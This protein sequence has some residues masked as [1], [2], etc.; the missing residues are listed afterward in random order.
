[1][2]LWLVWLA[3]QMELEAQTE[4]LV[5]KIQPSWLRSKK[6]ERS[7]RLRVRLSVVLS[8]GLSF[9]LIS[10]LSFGLILGLSVGLISGLMVV[11]SGLMGGLGFGLICY[12]I[13]QKISI[14][15][16]V[17]KSLQ[18]GLI[19]WLMGGLG[20]GL[21]FG[22]RGGLRGGLI[23]GLMGGLMGDLSR[24]RSSGL[25]GWLSRGNL[26][27]NLSGGLGVCIKH[28]VLRQL[29]Y[30]NGLA[31]WNYAR[32]LIDCSDCLLLQRIGGRFRFIHK[33]VQEHFAAMEF[34]RP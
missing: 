8:V 11:L 4:F 18:L 31:P 2:R 24:E 20:F 16:G 17:W 25:A 23:L 9:G 6:L 26:G 33:T 15:Q 22:L 29:L 12:E 13:E 10:G 5:E 34:E 30:A 19:Q 14:N 28:F 32:F 3:K 21:I 27:G 7:Y 1:M